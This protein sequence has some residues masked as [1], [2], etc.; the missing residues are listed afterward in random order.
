MMLERAGP[1]LSIAFALKLMLTFQTYTFFIL[2]FRTLTPSLLCRVVTQ[3]DGVGANSG[4]GM[5]RAS[6]RNCVSGSPH[7]QQ[8]I[9]QFDF[10]W[11]RLDGSFVLNVGPALESGRAR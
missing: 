5:G 10:C 7:C 2:L 3:G 1:K 6:K 11:W 9:V 4:N 8:H